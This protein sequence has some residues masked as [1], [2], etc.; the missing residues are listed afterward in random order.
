MVAIAVA[1]VV[2]S[3]VAVNLVVVSVVVPVPGGIGVR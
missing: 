3:N 2:F 1:I